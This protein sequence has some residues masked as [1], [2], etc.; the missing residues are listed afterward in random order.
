MKK[1]LI[2]ILAI[3]IL[4]TAILA[5]FNFGLIKAA[6]KTADKVDEKVVI[7]KAE[8]SATANNRAPAIASLIANPSTISTGA[9]SAITC[10]A[11]DADGD[12]LIYTWSAA[13]G[14]ISGTGATVNWTAPISSSTYTISVTVSDG[15][16]GSVQSSLNV[17][18]TKANNSPIISS[19]V[20]NPTTISTG[21]V[22]AI[23][24]TASDADGDILTYTWSAA[25][26]TISGTGATIN[27]TAPASSSTYTIGVTVSD[28][29]GG[30]AQTSVNVTAIK[31]NNS[32][33]ISSLVANPATISTGA[34]SAI[35]CSASDTD[36]DTLTYTWSAASGTISGTGTTVNWTAPASSSTY[37]INV[38]VTDGH[39][40]S[41]QSSVNVVTTRGNISPV[42]SSVVPNPASL[43]TGAVSALTC[44]A[45][46]AD[47][48]TLTY[49]WSTASGTISGT[50]AIVNWTAPASSSTYIINV[51]VTD[52]H[53]GSAQSSVN[54]TVTKL[55]NSP[56]ISSLVANPT[57]ILTSAATTI[58]CSASDA[59]GDTLTYSWSAVSGT[60]SGTG[61]AITWTAPAAA[62]TYVIN[63]TVS[64]GQGGTA[65]LSVNVVVAAPSNNALPDT[66][67]TGS[68]TTTF[69]EDHDYQP[70]AAQM[71]YTDNG[72]GT[73][74]DNRT[75]LIW[76]KDGNSAGCNNGAVLTWE[77][78]LTFCEGLSYAGYSD[79]RLPN[80]R[81]LESIVNNGEPLPAIT[82]LSFPN[83]KSSGYW[84]ST[85]DVGSTSLAWIINF[86]GGDIALGS[87]TTSYYVRCVRAGP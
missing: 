83:T 73:I 16:G 15:H 2:L 27:W 33:A 31:S 11:S 66:G 34:V 78:A 60:I 41:A 59:D 65:Q 46:D 39:G 54:V 4:P 72:N 49:S 64:D 61:S 74:T 29:H 62:S 10:S 28:G 45:S 6:K 52:G 84:A 79:W 36:G 70:A 13:S 12:I 56:L 21:A 80:I 58:T 3:I 48:D 22:S 19:V 71:S 69:G 8:I 7:K 20:A 43:S 42:I 44:S 76:V 24:C 25:S 77:Q 38:T 35:T 63:V 85:T 23:T 51:T 47:G 81:E 9:I 53:G 40:G 82:V 86:N 37:V 14:T 75:D 57:S 68:Y 18:V 32:P 30:S 67:Q 5:G 87:K 26:G 17:T 50:G 1:L 55:N